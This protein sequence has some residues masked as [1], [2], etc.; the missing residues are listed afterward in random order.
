MG[1]VG[2]SGRSPPAAN[3]HG[4]NT[5]LSSLPVADQQRIIQQCEKQ[6]FASGQVLYEINV[7]LT[8]GYFPLSG[9]ASLVAHTD[10]AA[11]EVGIVG[12]EGFVGLQLA[13]GALQSSI[14]AVCQA[15][16]EFLA[17]PALALRREL[18]SNPAM[19]ALLARFT[20]GV[21]TQMSQ[22][23]LCNNAHAV[24]QRLCRW[25]L[26]AHDRLGSDELPLTQTFLSQMLGV[27]RPSV[28]VAAGMLKKAGFI[29]YSRGHITVLDR[30]GLEDGACECYLVIRT[31]FER[32]LP[33]PN[34][35]LVSGPTL[36]R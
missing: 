36:R 29:D 4:R 12:N 20:Q 28:T 35:E 19:R 15:P 10:G 5:L 3:S 25:L 9:F 34:S 17:L 14:R 21:M 6:H 22:S 8:H 32:L 13:L 24:D 18:E 27:R 1:V 2:S 16:G 11:I 30:P 33:H 7:P 26:A 23:M 31:E